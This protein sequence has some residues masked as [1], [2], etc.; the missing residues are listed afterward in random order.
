MFRQKMDPLQL[1]HKEI[2]IV[3]LFRLQ[4]LPNRAILHHFMFPALTVP[5]AIKQ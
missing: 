5:C 4:P 1:L 2:L 3:K